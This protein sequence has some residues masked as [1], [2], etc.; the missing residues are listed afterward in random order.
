MIPVMVAALGISCDAFTGSDS[1]FDHLEIRLM[2]A[3]DFYPVDDAVRATVV[4]VTGDGNSA[5]LGSGARWR[6][7]DPAI[8]SLQQGTATPLMHTLARGNAT[9]EVKAEG[10]TARMQLVVKG[11]LH[12]HPIASSETWLAADGPHV[13]QGYLTVG[14]ADTAVLTI[15]PGTEVF[16]RPKSGLDF[17]ALHPGR[18][19]IPAGGAAVSMAGDSAGTGSWVGLSFSGAGQSEL[20]N[21]TFRHCGGAPTFGTMRGCVIAS[22]NPAGWAPSLL[23]DGV[24]ITG[25]QH[26]GMTLENWVT[27]AAGSRNLTIVDGD[28]HIATISPVLAG[29][30]PLG[31]RFEGNAENAIWIETGLVAQSTTWVSPGVPWRLVGEV[32]VEGVDDP[33]LTV[34]AGAVVRASAGAAFIIGKNGRGQL[35]VGDAAGPPVVLESSGAGWRGIEISDGA[36]P[37]S[38]RRVLMRDCGLS[39]DACVQVFG[40]VGNGTRLLVDDVTIRGSRS[41]GIQL[42]AEARFDLGSRSLTVLE[43]AS[44]PVEMPPDAV[45][46]LPS[47]A[48][49]SNASDVIRLRGSDVTRTATWRHPGVP[50]QAPDGLSV[51][52]S[53]NDPI[54]T[55]EGGVVVQMGS[56]TRLV[57]AENLPG[58]LRILGTASD[59]VLLGSATPGTPGAW[60]GVELG[61]LADSRTRL[62]HVEIRDAGAGDAGYAGAVRMQV[63]PGGVLRNTTIRGSS[64]CGVVLFNAN[65][66]AEDYAD[67]LFGNVFI[68]NG[69][70]ALCRPIS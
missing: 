41:M 35:V 29:H 3:R 9:I 18:L 39:E 26:V 60:M 6:T 61:R 62:V 57:V 48:Y 46:S 45:G 13:V 5:V 37:S 12:A 28:G 22:R 31:G 4:G 55:L 54:L 58:A 10:L 14:E 52:H 70:P 49:G 59:P 27:L 30:L 56:N 8:V 7:L 63:D 50:Y 47:G 68:D 43:S 66:W 25:A 1:R 11:I 67:P 69:G 34:P 44:V 23:I 32:F 33:V 16:F 40:G 24:T 20:R 2:P 15:E 36:G 19:V 64:S 53:S 21:V 38:L 42:W 65:A 17:G 51:R